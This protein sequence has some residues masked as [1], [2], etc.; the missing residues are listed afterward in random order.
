MKIIYD[1]SQLQNEHL[2]TMIK[3]AFDLEDI[4]VADKLLST[5]DPSLN[6]QETRLAEDAYL[7]ACARMDKQNKPH[8]LLVV[9]RK[10]LP[11]AINIA[12]CIILL[13]A[14]AA[15]V[16]LA[17]SATFRAKVMQL[18]MELDDEK[19]EAHFSFVANENATFDVPEDWCGNYFP[20]YIPDGFM[21]YDYDP[22]FSMPIIE[23]RDA[24]ENQLFFN[25]YNEHTDMMAGT[26]KCTISSILIN[27]NPG[28]MIEG[29]GADGVTLGVTITWQNDTNWFCVTTF[30][31][32]TDEA[33]QIARSVRRIIK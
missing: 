23:Y 11:W 5:A 22:N 4:E 8:A 31:L 21:I 7:L 17:N 10:A 16:A 32:S 25:E 33:L 24:A 15:P 28:I 3:L 12:A 2:D 13:L 20:S 1:A 26:E 6:A 30:G 18:I 9:A 29:P 27:G 14:I 19:G